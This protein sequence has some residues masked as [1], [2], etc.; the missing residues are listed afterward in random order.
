MTS[1][2]MPIGR[3]VPRVDAAD[4]VSGAAQFTDD[5]QFGPGLLYGI[6]DPRCPT[7]GQMH[8][9]FA[10][11]QWVCQGWDGEGCPHLVTAEEWLAGARPMGAADGFTVD[12]DPQEQTP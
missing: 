2:S 3:S 6:P 1:P 10:T 5:L 11:D 12:I 4:K 7:H 8:H 9:D